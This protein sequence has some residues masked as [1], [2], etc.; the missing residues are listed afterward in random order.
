VTPV[1]DGGYRDAIKRLAEK[2]GDKFVE[3]KTTE[4]QRFYFGE[5][6]EV[7]SPSGYKRRGVISITTGWAPS[8]MLIYRKSNSGSWDLLNDRD[9]IV[10]WIDERSVRHRVPHDE[11]EVAVYLAQGEKDG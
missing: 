11:L 8:L 10:A 9:I 1:I 5:R 6:V 2:H 4:I 7:V 3:P